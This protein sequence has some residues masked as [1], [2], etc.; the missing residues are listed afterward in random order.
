V[1]RVPMEGI[2]DLSGMHKGSVRIV[3][4]HGGHPLECLGP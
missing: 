4:G 2:K 3:R 1:G